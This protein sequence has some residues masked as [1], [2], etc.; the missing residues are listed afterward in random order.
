VELLVAV[1]ISSA[2]FGTI[3]VSGVAIYRCCVASDDYSYQTN[4]QLRAVDFISRDLRSALSV[5]I[6]PGGQ[7]VALTLP[8]I[9]SSYD[10]KGN[11]LS[12]PVTPAINAGVPEYGNIAQ[13]LSITYYVSGN[14]LLRQQTVPAIA[15]TTTKVIARNVNDLTLDF[16]PMST[17]VNFSIKFSPRAHQGSANLK[18]GTTV[19]ATVAARMLRFK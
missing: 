5:T 14:S 10:S 15:Q 3:L 8:D 11:P 16:V 6:P 2:I 18:P 17:A 12:A 19:A 9:Y 13:P 1:A 7:T 4:E